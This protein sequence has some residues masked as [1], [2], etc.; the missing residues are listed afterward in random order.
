MITRIAHGHGPSLLVRGS[1]G[2]AHPGSTGHRP[3]GTGP[4]CPPSITGTHLTRQCPLWAGSPP[5][6]AA[7]LRHSTPGVRCVGPPGHLRNVTPWSSAS[8]CR[9]VAVSSDHSAAVPGCCSTSR[10]NNRPLRTRTWTHMPKRAGTRRAGQPRRRAAGLRW[11]SSRRSRPR[12]QTPE[13]RWPT[14][15]SASPPLLPPLACRKPDVFSASSSAPISSIS[16]QQLCRLASCWPPEAR[17]TTAR[18]AVRT[19]CR[20]GPR[21]LA[22]GAPCRHGNNRRIQYIALST[23]GRTRAS[24]R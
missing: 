18:S 9:Q 2:P 15:C 10:C 21:R 22:R 20:C 19:V 8:T 7:V 23:E 14:P 13:P 16:P 12:Q 17:R 1:P 5:A 11:R 3:T 24:Y 4:N 6:K